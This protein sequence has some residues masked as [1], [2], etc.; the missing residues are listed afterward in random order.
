MRYQFMF[1]A[2]LG[3][4]ASPLL[5]AQAQS[6]P[7]AASSQQAPVSDSDAK[8]QSAFAK[9]VKEG[10][11]AFAELD[12]KGRGSLRRSDIPKDVDALKLLR[13]HFDQFDLDHSG[14]LNASE[15]ANYVHGG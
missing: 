8:P 13:A 11:P 10:A 12:K 14:S 7:A 2:F 6:N 1:M 4:A 15:Y 9:P 5:Q 3:L